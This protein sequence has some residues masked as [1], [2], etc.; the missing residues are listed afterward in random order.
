MADSA[1]GGTSLQGMRKWMVAASQVIAAER[2]SQSG[3]QH[4]ANTTITTSMKSTFKPILDGSVL[5]KDEKQRLAKERREEKRRQDDT[6]KEMQTLE[7]ERKAKIYHEKQVEEKQRKLKEQKEKDGQRRISVEKR[8]QKLEEDQERYKAVLSRIVERSNS[9]MDSKERWSWE[10]PVAERKP[11]ADIKDGKMGK[12]SSSLNRK[13]TNAQLHSDKNQPAGRLPGTHALVPCPCIS[14]YGSSIP[15][16]GSKGSNIKDESRIASCDRLGERFNPDGQLTSSADKAV[17]ETNLAACVGVSLESSPGDSLNPSPEVSTESSEALS[18]NPSPEVS[19]DSSGEVSLGTS[20]P[21]VSVEVLPEASLIEIPLDVKVE[22]L[23][24]HPMELPCAQRE[25]MR[26]VTRKPKPMSQDLDLGNKITP[27]V[28]NKEE[29]MKILSEKHR[30]ICEQKEK[31]LLKDARKTWRFPDRMYLFNRKHPMMLT[32]RR[33]TVLHRS[34]TLLKPQEGSS[35]LDD[36]KKGDTKTKAQEEAD[37]CKKEHERIMLQNLKERLERKKR[38][39]EIMKQARRTDS[40]LSKAAG[41]LS[42]AEDADDEDEA[43]DEQESDSEIDLSDDRNS[44]ASL[45]SEETSLKPQIRL[46]NA[47]KSTKMIF[48]DPT[49]IQLRP[50][51]RVFFN[52]GAKSA[53]P[54][55]SKG[56]GAVTKGP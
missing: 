56:A 10:G 13:Y 39:E 29:A 38:I 14:A 48:L 34:K 37:K 36:Q 26:G 23:P 28:V 32:C 24:E 8:K 51:T 30:L 3:L 2:R 40:I 12:R 33:A 55:S 53:Q 46:R 5:K 4:Q 42:K 41:S 50:G 16:S 6:N 47:K 25:R 22:V 54:M 7:K 1:S 21:D 18:V 43:D 52:C 9:L 19:I 20:S 44:P 15:E 45:S 49:S 17:C 11:T 27:G 35:E 31:E